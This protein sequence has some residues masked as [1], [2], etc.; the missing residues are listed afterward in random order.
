[1]E[2][3][4]GNIVIFRPAKRLQGSTNM[5]RFF[6]EGV[7]LAA[8]LMFAACAIAAGSLHAQ[9]EPAAPAPEQPVVTSPLVERL[10]GESYETP[11]D[12]LNAVLVMIDAKHAFAARPFVE[13]LLASQLDD[14]QLAALE[15]RFGSAA[16]LKLSTATDLQPEG[17][18]L[19]LD[20]LAA[21]G[22]MASGLQSSNCCP[23]DRPPS[24]RC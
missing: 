9:D 12:R 5:P 18:Q 4:V 2:D 24:D 22:R 13:Q 10:L 23:P 8:A 1:M 19:S 3:A 20:I 16:I 6:A 7:R 21:A 17:R 15:R 14:Q 11:G